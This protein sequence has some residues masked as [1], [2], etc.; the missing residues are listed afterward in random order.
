MNTHNIYFHGEISKIPKT[1]DEKKIIWS[2]V[3]CLLTVIEY[4]DLDFYTYHAIGRFS[5]PQTG[6]IVFLENRI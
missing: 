1:H 6:D 2:C 3:V 4:R 5:R